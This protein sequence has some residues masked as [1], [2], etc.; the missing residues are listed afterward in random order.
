MKARCLRA[1]G[2][3]V[4]A[5]ACT[6]AREP[7]APAPLA[8]APSRATAEVP[9]RIEI[10]GRDLVAGVKADFGGGGAGL[11]AGFSAWLE[12]SGAG[13]AIPL[14]AV[15]LTDRRTILATV[16]PGLA[17]GTYRLVVADPKGRTGALEHA[18]RVVSSAAA[19]ARF[20]VTLAERRPKPK[21]P[22]AVVVTA[23]DAGGGVVE[24][25]EGTVTLSDTAGAL[26]PRK[27]G[28]L[29]RGRG[30]GKVALSRVVA[31]D[32]L[33]AS[34]GAGHT[35]TSAGFS[36]EGG[37]PMALVFASDPVTVAAGDCS[38]RVDLALRDGAGAAAVAP[39]ALPVALQSAP[40]GLATFTDARCTAAAASLTIPAGEGEAAFWFRAA[41]AGAVTVRAVPAALPN[42][43]Q[44]QTVTP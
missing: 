23:V 30:R 41:S 44:R 1:A 5:L 24:G 13:T 18:Y 28:P 38:P 42:A 40:P 8:V 11:D 26:A 15:A 39:A 16:P 29:V 17:A 22:F 4:L 20:E 43:V 33:T 34:D 27:H 9:V 6:R 32:R 35:G 21:I 12:P 2:L 37:P 19:V 31:G 25:Y 3:V 7:G 36:V 14:T 10:S